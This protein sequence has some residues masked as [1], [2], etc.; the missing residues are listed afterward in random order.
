[1][2]ALLFALLTVV[3]ADPINIS[4][5]CITFSVG[6]GTG[7]QWMCDYCATNLGTNNYYF[8][9]DVC[10]YEPVG[11]VIDTLLETPH[12]QITS[13]CVGNPS[14]GVSYTCCSV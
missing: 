6:S 11:Y 10:K 8:T 4:N 14:A 5:G 12:I 9:T 7:C 2:F 13:G 3:T 1:M